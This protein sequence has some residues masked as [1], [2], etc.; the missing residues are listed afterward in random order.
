M[1]HLISILHIRI[2]LISILYVVM[3]ISVKSADES[4]RLVVKLKT[5][6]IV[7]S[8]KVFPFPTTDSNGMILSGAQ[9]GD[10]PMRDLFLHQC[11]PND[12]PRGALSLH[13]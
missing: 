9:S 3:A 12:K 10:K 4:V 7:K 13:Q 8:L 6:A 11:P 5:N 1:L 2:G